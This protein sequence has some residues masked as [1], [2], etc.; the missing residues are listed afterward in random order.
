MGAKEELDPVSCL[1]NG[2]Q[3][4]YEQIQQP[5]MTSSC[6]SPNVTIISILNAFFP[7]TSL[8]LFL[9]AEMRLTLLALPVALS[10]S[11]T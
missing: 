10:D 6:T 7:L 11:Y 5:F 4:L 8:S 3:Q 9:L 1:H 2:Q